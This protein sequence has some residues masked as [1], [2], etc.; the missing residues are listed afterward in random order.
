MRAQFLIRTSELI[1][2]LKKFRTIN[3]RKKTTKPPGIV[4]PLEFELTTPEGEGRQLDRGAVMYVSV[5][6]T[7]LLLYVLGFPIID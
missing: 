1:N 7:H 3:Q 2:V 4:N 6:P 5:V